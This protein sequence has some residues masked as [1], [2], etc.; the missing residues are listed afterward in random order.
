MSV[1]IPRTT[2]PTVPIH[3]VKHLSTHAKALWSAW[4]KGLPVSEEAW[5]DCLARLRVPYVPLDA[6]KEELRRNGWL[7]GEV[8]G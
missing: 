3:Q 5:E 7:A 1:T 8:Q 6:Y 4:Q 2:V